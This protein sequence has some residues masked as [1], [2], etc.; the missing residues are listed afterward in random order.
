MYVPTR[1]AIYA[2]LFVLSTESPHYYDTTTSFAVLS[3]LESF[4]VHATSESIQ[5]CSVQEI[6]I[7]PASL[8]SFSRSLPVSFAS[9]RTGLTIVYEY[10][11]L[12]VHYYYIPRQVLLCLQLQYTSTISD[13][14]AMRQCSPRSRLLHTCLLISPTAYYYTTPLYKTTTNQLYAN[15]PQCIQVA[16]PS[17]EVKIKV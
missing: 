15:S 14:A 2:I 8:V 12:A 9:V 17:L 1:H 11:T 3:S 10:L 6:L 5:T 7:L 16:K 4:R 13:P